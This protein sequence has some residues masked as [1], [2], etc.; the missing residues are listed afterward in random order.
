MQGLVIEWSW[1]LGVC[2]AAPTH[3]CQSAF[4]IHRTPDTLAGRLAAR[5]SCRPPLHSVQKSMP[6]KM[7]DLRARCCLQQVEHSAGLGANC[8]AGGPLPRFT[9]CS[10]VRQRGVPARPSG[11]AESVSGQAHLFHMLKQHRRWQCLKHRR[12]RWRC[13]R[14]WRWHHRHNILSVDCESRLKPFHT[15]RLVSFDSILNLWDVLYLL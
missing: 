2:F 5:L 14:L 7:G 11:L 15:T 6:N 10:S 9:G 13:H 12:W 4:D 3:S 1:N 8:L